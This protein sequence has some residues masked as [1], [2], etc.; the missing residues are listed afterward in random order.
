MRAVGIPVRI[1]NGVTLKQPYEVRLPNGVMA[2]RMAQGRHSWIEVFFPGL[3]WTP[4]DP[5]QTELFVSN[6]FLRVEIG[7][8]NEETV[9]DGNVRFKRRPGSLQMPMFQEVI[10][11][12]FTRD[13]VSLTGERMAWGPRRLLFSPP[14]A[15][16]Y[17]GSSRV[18]EQA[19]APAA[20]F[21]PSAG[22][23]YDKPDTLGNLDFPENL[24]FL[25]A[26]TLEDQGGGEF[27]LRK[28]FL[29]ETAEYVTG[30]GE[31]YAQSFELDRPMA[32][33]RVGL[34]LHRFGGTGDLWVELAR[35]DGSGR[36]GGLLETSEL[37]PS[38][39]VSGRPGYAWH[40]FRF[41]RSGPVLEP[42]R[43]W[44][45]LAYSG[46][47]VVNWFFSYGKNAGPSDGTRFNVMFD[48]TWSR[49]LSYEFN[50]RL[51]GS[52]SR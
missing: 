20:S 15:S 14:L 27:S 6:R 16:A 21:S 49:S 25:G 5:Q 52:S 50:F 19:E 36:P 45:V 7:T 4:F 29:V 43:Y 46:S 30:R 44:I 40:D 32:L 24:D 3:G 47:P 28:N 13:Q 38:S 9:N 42:G 26:R 35:D 33:E 22:A 31:R 11:A 37:V 48:E 39:S 51:I 34:A 41:A 1:V 10:A 17:S 18:M 23:S 8:D 12:E 2:M